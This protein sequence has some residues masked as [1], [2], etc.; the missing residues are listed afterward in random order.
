[1]TQQSQAPEQAQ[2]KSRR[3]MLEEFVVAHPTDGFAQYGLA[4]EC[5]STGDTA[6]AVEN[7]EKLLASHP[8]YV[9]GYFQY[10]QLLARLSRIDDARRILTAGIEAAHRAGDEHAASEMA[11]ALAQL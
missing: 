7:Y 2:K 3:A 6:A 4:M 8:Q 10:G 1:M 5:A 9:S 11:T